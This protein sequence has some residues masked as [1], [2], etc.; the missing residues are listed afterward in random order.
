MALQPQRPR[1]SRVRSKQTTTW[2]VEP[3]HADNGAP[4]DGRANVGLQLIPRH[5]IKGA[6]QQSIIRY[7]RPGCRASLKGSARFH[8][9]Q[10]IIS[11]VCVTSAQFVLSVVFF[12][13]KW[14]EAPWP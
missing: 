12:E 5:C 3:A 7:A 8:L 9:L 11:I 4:G 6:A 1:G 13:P 2:R 14:R 10:S